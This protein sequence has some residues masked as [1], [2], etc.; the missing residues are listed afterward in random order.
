MKHLETCSKILANQQISAE[1]LVPFLVDY[2]IAQGKK[3]QDITNNLPLILQL[4]QIGAFDII[5]AIKEYTKI[6]NKQLIALKDSNGVILNQYI[7]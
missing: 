6:S 4:V 5:Y 7:V 1:E 2:C 3:E